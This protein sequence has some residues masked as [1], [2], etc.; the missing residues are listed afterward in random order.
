[1]FRLV[2]FAL[3]A[4]LHMTSAAGAACP[5]KADLANGI[6]MTLADGDIEIHRQVRPDWVQITVTFG[7]DTG[8]GSV[9]ELYHGVYLMSVIP[10]ENRVLKPGRIESYATMSDLQRWAEPVPARAWSNP[11]P[12]GGSAK[13]GPVETFKVGAC[14]YSGFDMLIDFADDENYTETYRVLP[15]LG[16]ALLVRSDDGETIETYVYTSISRN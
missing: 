16:T 7:D 5:T 9:M 12:T 6:A 14:N 3:T 15:D 10:I 4:T 1:M 11:T 2:A 13:S 8:D